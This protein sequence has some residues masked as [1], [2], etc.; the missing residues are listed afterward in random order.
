MTFKSILKI[1]VTATLAMLIG[2]G[3]GPN[4]GKLKGKLADPLSDEDVKKIKA[5]EDKPAKD[6]DNA[7]K[8]VLTEVVF[9]QLR[10]KLDHKKLNSTMC[11]I[12]AV[13]KSKIQKGVHG[14]KI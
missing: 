7:E 4:K 3:C 9:N 11:Q 13:G 1:L 5:L 10:N 12:D 14:N 8:G 2:L 6:L